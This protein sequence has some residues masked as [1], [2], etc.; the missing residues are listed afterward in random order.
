MDTKSKC[1][2]KHP[3][4]YKYTKTNFSYTYKKINIFT[5]KIHGDF[6]MSIRY[7]LRLKIPCKKCRVDKRK[8]GLKDGFDYSKTNFNKDIKSKNIFICL[9]H[10]EFHRT[11][12]QHKRFKSGGCTQ[13][14]SENSSQRQRMNFETFIG[15]SKQKY[16]K[17]NYNYSKVHQFKNQ[18][19]PVVIICSKKDHGAFRKTP[20]NH[21]NKSNP[22]GCP[23]CGNQRGAREQSLTKNEFLT[24]AKRIHGNTYDYSNVNFKNTKDKIKLRCKKC[25]NHFEQVVGYHLSGSGCSICGIEKGRAANKTLTSEIIVEKCIEVWGDKYDYSNVNYIDDDTPIEIICKKHGS[26]MIDYQNHVGLKRGCKFCGS[27]RRIK[28]SEWLNY[29]GIP[30]S[31]LN[32]EVTIKCSDGK[33][34]Y[35]DGYDPDTKTVYEFNGDYFHGNPEKYDSDIINAFS[36]KTMK[37]AFEE[38]KDKKKKLIKNGYKVID[39]WEAEWDKLKERV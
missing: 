17:E 33:I 16:I 4:Q 9:K 29:I 30:E 31:D 12:E 8:L 37:E 21:L 5:C 35:V 14:N 1:Q 7:F 23:L 15:L 24:A 28:Q 32:R 20:A 26:I 38:T 10:G 27:T 3:D 19:E 39:I 25:N 18:H 34:Y 6:N 13:C 11:I 36:K 2:L 22:Q